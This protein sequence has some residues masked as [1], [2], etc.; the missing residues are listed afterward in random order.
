[1]PAPAALPPRGGRI[2]LGADS[3]RVWVGP[4]VSLDVLE[5]RKKFFKLK[6]KFDPISYIFAQ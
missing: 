5:K 4:R 2:A 1:M 3:L 6:Q